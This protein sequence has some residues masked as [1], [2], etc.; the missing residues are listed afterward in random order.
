MSIEFRVAFPR[1]PVA[2]K[3]TEN[4]NSFRVRTCLSEMKITY[5]PLR[6]IRLDETRDGMRS[7]EREGRIRV[8]GDYADVLGNFL[9]LNDICHQ[10]FTWKIE[11]K[12]YFH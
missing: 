9:H 6:M 7:T 3:K 5:G 4:A 8:D 2:H 11:R 10:F 1:G 12:Y